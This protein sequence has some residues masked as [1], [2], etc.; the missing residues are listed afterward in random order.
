MIDACTSCGLRTSNLALSIHGRGALCACCSTAER[1]R[2]AA[3]G[4]RR[5]YRTGAAVITW[6]PFRALGRVL[7]R[8]GRAA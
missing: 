5:T 7:L 3:V 6:A 1:A 2:D 4:D 8:V